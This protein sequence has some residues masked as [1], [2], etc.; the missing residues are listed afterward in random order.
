MKII[1]HSGA[2]LVPTA[3]PLTCSKFL[4]LYSKALFFKTRSAKRI[5][6]PLKLFD[7]QELRLLL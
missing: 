3:K 5:T 6:S 1:V 2:N 7:F 4:L